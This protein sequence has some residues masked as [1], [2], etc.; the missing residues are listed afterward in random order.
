MRIDLSNFSNKYSKKI[1]HNGG[2]I[3]V[4]F[5]E[6]KNVH[7]VKVELNEKEIARTITVILVN[8]Q[9]PFKERLSTIKE[10]LEEIFVKEKSGVL[11][12]IKGKKYLSE[13][14]I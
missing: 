10:M 4:N 11:V 6:N 2:I 9:L 7:S 3:R 8:G 12:E 14:E 1:F 13:V 5:D